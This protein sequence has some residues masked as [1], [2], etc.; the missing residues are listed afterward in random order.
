MNLINHFNIEYFKFYEIKEIDLVK[1]YKLITN[2]IL[3]KQDKEFY[4]MYLNKYI[5]NYPSFAD[6]KKQLINSKS[7]KS[8]EEIKKDF[9]NWGGNE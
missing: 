4:D 9:L 1:Y 7:K 2:Y 8:H 3:V 6:F 5:N